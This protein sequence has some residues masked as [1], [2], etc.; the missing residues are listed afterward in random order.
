VRR[1]RAARLAQA[2]GAARPAAAG[3]A[4]SPTAAARSAAVG[5]PVLPVP[6]SGVVLGV[7]GTRARRLDGSRRLGDAQQVEQ[8][9]A[10]RNREA[11]IMQ[12]RF[13]GKDTTNDQ[14]PT[15]YDTDETYDGK[16]VYVVQG[17]KVTDAETLAQL[18]M[19]E[20]E[21][22]VIVPKALM[23]YLPKATDGADTDQA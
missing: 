16:D 3:S 5:I 17:W 11:W 14:S 23:K 10:K 19:P 20:H 9:T 22:A 21:T 6:G 12:L 18:D 13:L 8:S 1:A 4:R 2:R 7:C 15:L